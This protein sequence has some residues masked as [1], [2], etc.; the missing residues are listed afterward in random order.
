MKANFSD[1]RKKSVALQNSEKYKKH[2]FT[3]E[4]ANL[5][6]YDNVPFP[7]GVMSYVQSL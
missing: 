6:C 2:M 4:C 5:E 7:I 3:L 1:T